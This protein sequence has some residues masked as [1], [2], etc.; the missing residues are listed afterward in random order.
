MLLLQRYE[1]VDDI[2]L[3]ALWPVVLRMPAVLDAVTPP[4]V[5]VDLPRVPVVE[6]GKVAG[7]NRLAF[8]QVRLRVVALFLLRQIASAA[9]AAILGR[10]WRLADVDRP[11]RS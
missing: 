7:R 11:T 6:K 8:D 1:R 5:V 10:S 9:S 2:A 3:E 4:S